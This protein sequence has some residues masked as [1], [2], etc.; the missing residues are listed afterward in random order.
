MRLSLSLRSRRITSSRPSA[1]PR[2]D[3]LAADEE[4]ARP[5]A[6]RPECAAARGVR[7]QEFTI[8]SLEK[9]IGIAAR[10][11]PCGSRGAWRRAKR[12]LVTREDPQVADRRSHWRQLP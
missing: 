6:G 10:K 11:Q 8:A 2:S 12:R 9:E 5:D 4:S 7:D 3:D 1:S